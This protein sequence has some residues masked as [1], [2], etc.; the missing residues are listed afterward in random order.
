MASALANARA[1]RE[2]ALASR[3]SVEQQSAQVDAL[4]ERAKEHGLVAK[5]AGESGQVGEWAGSAQ[6]LQRG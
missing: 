5:T 1:C 4:L 3:L 2:R 6:Q